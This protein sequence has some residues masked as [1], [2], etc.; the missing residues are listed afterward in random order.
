MEI[1]ARLQRF[2]D[3]FSPVDIHI[4]DVNMPATAL[5]ESSGDGEAYLAGYRT[6]KETPRRQDKGT[7]PPPVMRATLVIF[8]PLDRALVA[9]ATRSDINDEGCLHCRMVHGA[10]STH[11]NC[12]SIC[13]WSTPD[14]SKGR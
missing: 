14:R 4:E 2:G 9:I 12:K 3:F 7:V 5:H 11:F 13:Y 6:V 1:R 10:Q 8:N